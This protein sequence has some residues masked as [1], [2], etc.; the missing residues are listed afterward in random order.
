MI[1]WTSSYDHHKA[2]QDAIFSKTVL[3]R[4]E[5]YYLYSRR[6]MSKAVE[7]LSLL[8]LVSN[9]TKLLRNNID[10][11]YDLREKYPTQTRIEYE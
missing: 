5:K 3:P 1:L 4:G 9:L 8:S 7:L 11:D 2:D 10:E 6:Y